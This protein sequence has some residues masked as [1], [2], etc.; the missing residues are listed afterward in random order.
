M[1]SIKDLCLYIRVLQFWLAG[2]KRISELFSIV[3][4]AVWGAR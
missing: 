3:F 1:K 2:K 4:F